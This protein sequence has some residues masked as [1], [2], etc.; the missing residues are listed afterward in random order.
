VPGLSEVDSCFV[1]A[2]PYGGHFDVAASK[3]FVDVIR[4]VHMPNTY[5]ADSMHRRP[6]LIFGI[7][8]PFTDPVLKPS[9]T[10]RRNAMTRISTG[11]RPTRDA[12][13]IVP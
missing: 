9:T 7:H 3:H 6:F 2:I 12:A 4:S 10:H 5:D 13:K 1:I 8:Q 11:A